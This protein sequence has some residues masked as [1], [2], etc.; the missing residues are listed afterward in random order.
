MH[1]LSDGTHEND[2]AL[3]AELALE[4]QLKALGWLLPQLGKL[5][6]ELIINKYY[7]NFSIEELMASSGLKESAVKMRLSRARQKLRSQ[8]QNPVLPTR[9]SA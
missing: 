9:Q 2:T 3:E 1:A 7:N 4:E 5:D 6:R 8:L